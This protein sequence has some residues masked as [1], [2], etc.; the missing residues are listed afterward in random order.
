MC[1]KNCLYNFVY[2]F[3]NVFYKYYY[4]LMSQMESIYHKWHTFMNS[5]WMESK[6]TN[7]RSSFATVAFVFV[8]EYISEQGIWNYMFTYLVNSKNLVYNKKTKH[9]YRFFPWNMRTCLVLR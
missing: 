1:C 8:F 6:I 2:V 5:K 4:A 3:V 7:T 9:E